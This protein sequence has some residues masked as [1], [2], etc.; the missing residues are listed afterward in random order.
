MLPREKTL[1]IIFQAPLTSIILEVQI[2]RKVQKGVN[3]IIFILQGNVI[4]GRNVIN[5]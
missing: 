4:M 3:Y 5:C 2:A 1:T